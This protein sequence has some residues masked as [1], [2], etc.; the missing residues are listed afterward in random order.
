MN[1]MGQDFFLQYG[2]GYVY[3]SLIRAHKMNTGGSATYYNSI[4]D[5]SLYTAEGNKSSTPVT[6]AEQI[7]TF[8]NGVFPVKSGSEAA[9]SGM[10]STEL[11]ALGATVKAAMPLFDESKLTVDQKGNPR[12][13]NVMGA[14]VGE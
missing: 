8:A 11:A 1:N 9:T 2:T 12:T 6:F 10:S 5:T 3:N 7:G 14:Y 4:L 13:G